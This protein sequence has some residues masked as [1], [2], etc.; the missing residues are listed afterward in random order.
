MEPFHWRRAFFLG[1]VIY[2][3]SIMAPVFDTFVPVLLQSGHPLWQNTGA[4]NA[5]VV[6]FAL[7]P[8]LAFF[9]M[10]WDNLINLF[11]HPWAGARSDHTEGRW[12]RRKPWIVV[13]VPIAAIG[14][15]AIPFAPSL[16]LVALAILGTNIGRAIFVPPMI[17]W[18]GDLYAPDQRSQAN[19]AFGLVSGLAAI[20]VLIACGA[21]FERVGRAAPLSRR[22]V[23]RL[24]WRSWAWSSS[25]SRRCTAPNPGQPGACS[26]RFD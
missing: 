26:P 8:G 12:G 7:A 25:A 11:V 16:R 21:L 1:L 22:R 5:K 4:V 3:A 15:V 23:S 6:G 13:G 14:F 20:V 10:T 18:L 9:I 17:A 24:L 2:A 19:S